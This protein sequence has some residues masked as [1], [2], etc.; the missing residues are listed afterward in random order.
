L[1]KN[2]EACASFKNCKTF[3]ASSFS[4]QSSSVVLGDLN[5]LTSYQLEVNIFFSIF[6]TALGDVY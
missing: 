3:F 5:I 2:D 1:F 6:K 4:F